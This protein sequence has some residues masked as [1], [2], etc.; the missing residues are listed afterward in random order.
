MTRV[1]IRDF[2]PGGMLLAYGQVAQ[3]AACTPPRDSIISV[4]C[5]L[6]GHSASTLQFSG[7]VVRVDS[8]SIGLSFID[9]D[10]AA[11]RVLY[12]YVKNLREAEV[13]Q[14]HVT[15]VDTS[16]QPLRA[17]PAEL[18]QGCRQR[19]LAALPELMN[20]YWPAL[21]DRWFNLSN[22]NRDLS[23]ACF[24]AM[25]KI[26]SDMPLLAQ[27]FSTAMRDRLIKLAVE[28]TGTSG[29]GKA[30]FSLDGLSLVEEDEFQSWLLVA[31]VARN[32]EAD[33][34]MNLTNF[35]IR[36]EKL[37]GRSV[38]KSDNPFWPDAF[39]KALQDMFAAMQ[40]EPALLKSAFQVFQTV[41]VPA[42]E[43]IYQS[44]NE[45][46]ADAGVL[47]ELGFK[48]NKRP[49]STAAHDTHPEPAS[50]GSHAPGGAEPTAAAA[51]A[52]AIQHAVPAPLQSVP[53][54]VAGAAM[55]PP[56]PTPQE[57]YRIV[58]SLQELRS[59]VTEQGRL[60]QHEAEAGWAGRV[61]ADQDAPRQE[62]VAPQPAD[63]AQP[64]AT[65]A[66]R[67]YTADEIL[68]ALSS[69][70]LFG[71]SGASHHL[72]AEVN[73]MLLDSLSE[74]SAELAVDEVHAS[75]PGREASI[76]NL[77]GNLLDSVV[78]DRLVAESVRPWLE[79]LSIPLLK[80]AIRD[81]TLFSDLQHPARQLLNTLAQL[82]FYGEGDASQHR[83]RSRVNALLDSLVSKEH[84]SPTEI[85]KVVQ[86]LSLIVR[87][88]QQAFSENVRDVIRQCEAYEAQT[89][90]QPH[91]AADDTAL[92]A[93]VREWLKRLKHLS[94]G[95]AVLFDAT[96]HP[97]RLS[98]AWR[99][100]NGNRFA[101]VDAKGKLNKTL[102]PVE[103]AQMLDS[104]TAT[105]MDDGSEPLLDRAQYSMLQKMHREL[106]YETTHDPLTSLINRREFERQLE[107]LHQA[108]HEGDATGVVAYL[109][110]GQLNVVNNAFGYEG[111][112]RLLQELAA[113][114]RQ[115]VGER[116]VVGRLDSDEFGILLHPATRM[117]S[118]AI[119]NQ[120]REQVQAYR[121][122]Q[123][124]KSLAVTYSAG[125]V[126]VS[127]PLESYGE[128]LQAAESSC[129]TARD[130]G[131]YYV[132]VFSQSN[133]QVS[134]RMKMSKWLTRIDEA[135]DKGL[136]ELRY[137]PIARITPSGHT[138]HH[139]EIL[140]GVRN[141]EGVLISPVEF[142][143]AAEHLRRM[144][145]VDRW[146]VEK[147]FAWLAAGMGN[148][149]GVQLYS[150]NLSGASLNDESFADFII[151]RAASMHVPMDRVCF[152]VTETAGVNS[153][154]DAAAF[155]RRVRE[156]TG[157]AFSLDDFGSGMSSYAYLKNLP[158]DFLKIDGVFVKD[159]D[160]N[161]E[162]QAVV[163]SITEIGHFMGKQVIAE[164]VENAAI[165]QILRGIGVEFAQG[166]AI[167]R[168][169]SL[170]D[171]ARV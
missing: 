9:P 57:W 62:P 25:R 112:N 24:N 163:R 93:E 104:G 11:L 86:E 32:V 60:L 27:K 94:V 161:P 59:Q 69:L 113:I 145:A 130:K 135:L 47:P 71:H 1:E 141:D 51:P 58:Q 121:F 138:I 19:V 22:E 110:I 133:D 18:L 80:L 10:K 78:Q 100:K 29:L 28:D 23:Q 2:C 99:A 79:Q 137:Q 92:S 89:A 123:D 85:D 111:G 155:I 53:E 107:I 127:T 90:A 117:E 118:L 136:L 68:S 105:V 139:A 151:E 76:L 40:V 55:A 170:P 74:G 14:R 45:Y 171:S 109:D 97:Y 42:A 48:L 147:M 38:D 124:G 87:I 30:A 35:G 3:G 153:L 81:D 103:L 95:D 122:V 84:V 44:L 36:L 98:L 129:R 126:D 37:L 148:V 120:I 168:P 64:A 156:A 134:Q 31:D 125:L 41:L 54:P 12:A 146:V 144:T 157:C 96:T 149:D 114:L 56:M 82:E 150:I 165:L 20:A 128:V 61:S 63:T 91:N 17:S 162:D 50:L 6:P 158:V 66:T 39:A 160:K 142:I 132:Q 43:K 26:D 77:T 88:Q 167:G 116:G 15:A 166:Y 83:I 4:R 140:L 52:Q 21:K 33:C 7:K 131:S 119:M 73:A 49:S 72:A 67:E 159:L 164:Y 5:L 46:L 152:E 34:R 70:K 13:P 106:L 108:V 101:F 16:S 8:C 169:T 115:E 154:S 65:A 75:L 102:E 143:L